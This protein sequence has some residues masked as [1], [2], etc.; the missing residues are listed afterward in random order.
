MCRQVLNGEDAQGLDG[1][2]PGGAGGLYTTLLGSGR[3]RGLG[4]GTATPSIC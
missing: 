1:V 2:R 4:L 3:V